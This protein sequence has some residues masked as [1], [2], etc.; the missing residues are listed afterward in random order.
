M[1]QASGG[2]GAEIDARAVPIALAAQRLAKGDR[3]AAL[4][5]ALSDGEDHE[6]L[7]TVKKGRLLPSGGPLAARARKPIGR[8]VSEPGLWLLE[9]GRRHKVAPAGHEHDVAAD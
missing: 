2:F 4:V 7:F 5:R 1:L 6:L 9:N 3:K 8:V